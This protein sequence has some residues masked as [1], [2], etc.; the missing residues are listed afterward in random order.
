M[1]EREK[2]LEVDHLS[3]GYNSRQV[4]FDVSVEVRRGEIALLV[5]G[6]GCGKSTLLKAVYGLT[7]AYLNRRGTITFSGEDI[8]NAQPSSMIEKGLVYVPQHR[9][10]F[11]HLS[12]K[13]NLEVAATHLR[14]KTE[15]KT[16]LKDVFYNLPQLAT[17]KTRT[18]FQLSGGE[19][20][21]LALGMALIQRPTMV[22]LDEPTA[23]LAP[24]AVQRHWES[25]QKLNEQGITFLIVEHNIKDATTLA[26]RVIKMT[27][28]KIEETWRHTS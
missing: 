28:G 13:E 26:D 4:L 11:E 24:A 1:A 14:D 17:I 9:N 19:K 10:T 5:G 2:L 12:V 8:T 18:P 27:L 15:V 7:N 22:L 3:T 21:H 23:G 16:R 6:N 25:V 20:Q